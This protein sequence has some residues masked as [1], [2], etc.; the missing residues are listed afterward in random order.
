MD[1]LK[2]LLGVADP[3]PR[4]VERDMIGWVV[5]S[6]AYAELTADF[7]RATL[8]QLYAGQFLPP[9]QRN[10]VIDGGI[11]DSEFMIQSNIAGAAGLF[12][13]HMIPG[14]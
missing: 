9:G 13:L 14:A 6:K 10:F 7:L 12:L 4:E 3:A 8:D 1:F 2:R 5:L 11:P